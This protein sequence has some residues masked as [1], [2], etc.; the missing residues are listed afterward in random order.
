M[1]LPKSYI[2]R[3]GGITKAAWAAFRREK[4]GK[5]PQKKVSSQGAQGAKGGGSMAK[6]KGKKRAK[7]KA[8]VAAGYRRAKAAAESKPGKVIIATAEAGG[9]AII[10]SQIVNRAPVVSTMTRPAKA[11]VLGGAGFAGLVLLRKYK[12]ARMIVGAGGIL[13]ALLTLAKEYGKVD[14]LAGN[15]G[16]PLTPTEFERLRSGQLGMPLPG[17]MNMPLSQAPANAGFSG[18]FGS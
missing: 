8:V 7:A 3:F 2:K 6:K 4:G 17:R 5:G 1:K 15:G 13:A 18:G 10:L 11:L 14:A 12:H 16:R 9:G